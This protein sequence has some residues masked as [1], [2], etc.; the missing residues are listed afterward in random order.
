[1]TFDLTLFGLGFLP[2]QKNFGGGGQNGPPPNMAISSHMMM[3]LDKDIQW[4]EIFRN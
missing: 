4:V 3:K 1:M 2:T